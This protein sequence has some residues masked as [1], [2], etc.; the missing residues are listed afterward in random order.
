M[1]FFQTAIDWLSSHQTPAIIVISI[2]S[3]IIYRLII[4]AIRHAV[5]LVSKERFLSAEQAK[6]RAKTLGSV[7]EALAR[8]IIFFIATLMILDVFRIPIGPLLASAGIAGIA[9]GFGAQSLVKDFISGFFILFENQYSVGDVIQIGTSKGTVEDLDLRTTKLRDVQGQLHIIPNSEIKVVI[10]QSR[11]WARAIVDIGVSNKEDP[12]RVTQIM[13]DELAK[14]A[15]SVKV[16]EALLEPPQ[17]VGLKDFRDNVMVFRI[18]A[19]TKP[20]SQDEIADLIRAGMKTRFA[21][22]NIEMWGCSSDSP[23]SEEHPHL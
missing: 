15:K 19:M 18:T 9:I 5:E 13:E 20:G 8:F 6:L 23:N 17:V 14:I 21:K 2:L 3:I 10:N 7:L 12:A 1:E 11:G 4:I 22:E 16:K